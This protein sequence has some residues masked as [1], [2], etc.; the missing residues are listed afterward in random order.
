[1]SVH[2]RVL[3]SIAKDDGLK[4]HQKT[5]RWKTTRKSSS[6]PLTVPWAQTVWFKPLW[7]HRPVSTASK[8]CLRSSGV[9]RKGCTNRYD[10]I[11]HAL[12][13]RNHSDIERHAKSECCVSAC[14]RE[15]NTVTDNRED[16][17]KELCSSLCADV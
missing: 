10:A 6:I 5:S 16:V 4:V 8:Y 15:R 12:Y 14:I 1:M 7:A 13:S 11:N 9:T 2:E 3:E 17:L